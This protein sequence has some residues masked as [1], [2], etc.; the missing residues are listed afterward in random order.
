MDFVLSPSTKEV[1]V[2][3]VILN[4]HKASTTITAFPTFCQKTY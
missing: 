3:L 4:V 2:V 1:K